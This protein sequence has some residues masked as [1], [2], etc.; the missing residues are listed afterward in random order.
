MESSRRCSRFISG[1]TG[2]LFR[3][4]FCLHVSL[5]FSSSHLK[6]FVWRGVAYLTK[7]R[8]CF[9]IIHAWYSLHLRSFIWCEA[10][11]Y[12]NIAQR[13]L[14]VFGN[15]QRIS[16]DEACNPFNAQD[17]KVLSRRIELTN[18]FNTFELIMIIYRCDRF[19]H[20]SF[21]CE[22]GRTVQE[23]CTAGSL[24]GVVAFFVKLYGA[25]N[26]AIDQTCHF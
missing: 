24:G 1:W 9:C 25:S 2:C 17:L 21:R 5:T 3:F 15:L 16:A 26:L 6:T 10:C 18:Y 19:D 23:R 12:K 4:S 7:R 8:L 11:V 14:A 20:G 13:V 22:T